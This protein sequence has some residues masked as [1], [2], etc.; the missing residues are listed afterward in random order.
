MRWS[1]ARGTQRR[2]ETPALQAGNTTVKC[3]P[4]TAPAA[5]TYYRAVLTL[6]GVKVAT[7]FSSKGVSVPLDQTTGTF[8]GTLTQTYI[9]D[10]P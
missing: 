4:A 7:P 9:T 6:S 1:P 10:C 5:N 2:Y 3:T 8:N